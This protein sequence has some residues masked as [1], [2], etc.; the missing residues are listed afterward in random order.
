MSI[1]DLCR[2]FVSKKGFKAYICNNQKDFC[3]ILL[4]ACRLQWNYFKIGNTK[5]FFRDGKIE[6]L[7]EKLE[8]DADQILFR[9]NKLKML[10]SKFYFAILIARIAVRFLVMG[11]R[12]QINVETNVEHATSKSN[13]ILKEKVRTNRKRKLG[14]ESIRYTFSLKQL[15]GMTFGEFLFLLIQIKCLLFSDQIPVPVQPTTIAIAFEEG[16]LENE[17]RNLL[18]KERKKSVT[19]GRLLPT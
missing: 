5:V 11:K 10:R 13:D 8:S 17:L 1:A 14:T 9:I 16:S 3:S 2:K 15:I 19:F 18:K 7:T 4:R 6:L 12:S